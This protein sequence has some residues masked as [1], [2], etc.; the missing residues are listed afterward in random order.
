MPEVQFN[1]SSRP[2][3]T[4]KMFCFSFSGRTKVNLKLFILESMILESVFPQHQ[5][6]TL[7]MTLRCQ[8]SLFNFSLFHSTSM[9]GRNASEMAVFNLK[10]IIRC[11]FNHTS[12]EN[13]SLC[14]KLTHMTDNIP[15]DT[16]KMLFHS[17]LSS[18]V[19]FPLHT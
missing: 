3:R 19:V 2:A 1:I 17:T 18:F 4:V 8:N 13:S 5:H 11:D 16:E 14:K 7:I 6:E 12:N 9:E 10:L 15:T